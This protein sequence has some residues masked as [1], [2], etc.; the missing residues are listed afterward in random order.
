MAQADLVREVFSNPFRPIT[1]P[2]SWLP[3]NYP[4][5]W[6]MIGNFGAFQ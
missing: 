4:A 2:P 1:V 3:A 6:P 5:I